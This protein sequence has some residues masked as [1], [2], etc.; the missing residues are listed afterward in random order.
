MWELRY[1]GLVLESGPGRG[2]PAQVTACLREAARAAGLDA[3]TA[4][5]EREALLKRLAFLAERRPE[6]PALDEAALADVLAELCEGRR[7][8]AELRAA[9]PLRW[10]AARLGP[11]G[12]RLL[13]QAAPEHVTLPGG[14][15]CE[16]HYERRQPPWIQSRLQD[17]FGMRQGPE[18]AG[19]PLVLHLL[20][21]N[22][23]AVSVTSDLQ[24]FWQSA[25]VR[26]RKALQRRYPK[27]AW[28]EDPASASPPR[29]G[30]VR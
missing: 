30:K 2:E 17:F 26:E 4:A 14:R 18:V 23:V 20:A 19:V 21:P 1:G 5:P 16:V 8:F 7:S 29:P 3:L 25:Y 22:K 24:S 15:R 28:P 11:D 6:L 12:E 10:L 27:H 9:E 13:A